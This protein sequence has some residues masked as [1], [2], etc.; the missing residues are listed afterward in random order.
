[1]GL[2]PEKTLNINPQI[3]RGGLRISLMKA[4]LAKLDEIRK[5]NTKSAIQILTNTDHSIRPYVTNPNILDEYAMGTKD[6]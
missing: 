6:P 3:W 1:V 4:G 2:G 5:L